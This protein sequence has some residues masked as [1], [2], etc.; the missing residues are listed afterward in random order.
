[1]RYKIFLL[2]FMSVFL[3]NLV[4][5]TTYNLIAGETFSFES[6]EFEYY[7]VINNKS[8]MDGM[9]ISW[10]GNITISFSKYFAS[11]N[12]TILFFTKEKE[13]IHEYH[14]SGGGTRT[15]TIYVENKT[16]EYVNQTIYLNETEINDKIKK[17]EDDLKNKETLN[18]YSQIVIGIFLLTTFILIKLLLNK[19]K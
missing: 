9:N 3:I 5:A 4:N 15:R 6:E 14:S 17:L 19:R 2:L 11:D 8:N 12:F 18:N 13:I 1:M 7:T 16:T 10:D